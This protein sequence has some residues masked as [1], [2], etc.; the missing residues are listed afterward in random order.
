MPTW[1]RDRRRLPVW[2]L[3]IVGGLALLLGGSVVRFLRLESELVDERIRE[4]LE[5]AAEG[6]ATTLASGLEEVEAD[7]T[8]LLAVGDAQLSAAVAL[9]AEALGPQALILLQRDGGWEAHPAPRLLYSPFPATTGGAAEAVFLAAEKLEFQSARE[10]AAAAYRRLARSADPEVRAGALLR[11][12]R[13]LGRSDV[14]AA[15]ATYVELEELGATPVE[16]LPAALLGRANRC[17]LLADLGRRDDVAALAGELLA[18]LR[19]ARWRLPASA[20]AFH[21][22]QAVA[23]LPP[24]A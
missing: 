22:R 19:T 14:D 17:R 23:W 1:R 10:A 9:R 7:L 24:D 20:Y 16:G 18:D 11:L 21:T 3:T 5:T 4:R 2:I 8:A 15:L 6:V 12:A 13:V